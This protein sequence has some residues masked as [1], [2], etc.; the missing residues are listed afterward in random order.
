MPPTDLS[1]TV[2]GASVILSWKQAGLSPQSYV[3]LAG[4][5]PSTMAQVTATAGEARSW[6]IGYLLPRGKSHFV[7][8]AAVRDLGLEVSEASASIPVTIPT[9]P[10]ATVEVDCFVPSVNRAPYGKGPGFQGAY[11]EGSCIT[12]TFH[13]WDMRSR[14]TRTYGSIYEVASSRVLDLGVVDGGPHGSPY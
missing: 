6:D 8:L 13:A 5:T 4:P 1:V 12:G 9:V 3:L 11:A 10:A 14:L 7:A 2:S